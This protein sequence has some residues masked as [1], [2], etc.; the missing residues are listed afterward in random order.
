MNL[1]RAQLLTFVLITAAAAALVLLERL[2]PYNQEQKI[3]RR[4]FFDDLVFY[5]FLQS[6][7]L[8]LVISFFIQFLDQKASFSR[9]QL[10]ASR[11][12]WLQL[13]FFIVTHDFYIYWFHRWQHRSKY[14]WRLHEAHHSP[15]QVDWLSGVRS[16]AFEILIN[17]TVE[18]FP[19]VALGAAPEVAAYKGAVSAIWGMY[20]HSNIDVRSGV[21]QY[22]INGPEM[23]R[24][25]HAD[26]KSA[27]DR[28]FATK[29]AIWDWL[30]GTA[31][32]PCSRKAQ[33][34]GLG[35]FFPEGYFRQ[36]K[37]SFRKFERREAGQE[38]KKAPAAPAPQGTPNG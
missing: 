6:L 27:H 16:H 31:H 13:L 3:F 10:L 34:Y 36:H 17:Q 21:L 18:F 28:N 12:V 7:V 26:D 2:F 25:H 5:H 19:I 15:Q 1:N 9:L 20:I 32:L 33:H 35:Y 14:L 11:P 37:F 29:L 24:W 8:G 38:M 23:H 30:F 22:F 4:G